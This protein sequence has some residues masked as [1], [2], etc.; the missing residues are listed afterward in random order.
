M[1]V[2]TL[3]TL[4]QRECFTVLTGLELGGALVSQ[5]PANVPRFPALLRLGTYYGDF[6]GIKLMLGLISSPRLEACSFQEVRG[7]WREYLTFVDLISTKFSY[8]TE[9]KLHC[10]LIYDLREMDDL[11]AA[12]V[13]SLCNLSLPNLSN[14]SIR[15]YD[16]DPLSLL[17]ITW[18]YSPS[19]PWQVSYPAVL[20]SDL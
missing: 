16:G 5:L 11:Y 3:D 15:N 12:I 2:G 10:M 20:P 8:I 6:M 1:D 9:L 14:L 17:T 13:T 7:A 4:S 18:P 19:S